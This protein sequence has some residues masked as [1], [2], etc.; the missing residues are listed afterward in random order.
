MS[1]DQDRAEEFCKRLAML[2]KAVP[3]NATRQQKIKDAVFQ[4][5]R[6]YHSNYSVETSLPDTRSPTRLDRLATLELNADQL[7]DAV[8]YQRPN[9]E[10][11]DDPHVT[12]GRTNYA[13]GVRQANY[14]P[15]MHPKA[16][17]EAERQGRSRGVE[18]MRQIRGIPAPK[19]KSKTSG[20]YT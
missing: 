16:R 20:D 19:K 9:Y 13:A 18:W 4:Q 15:E 5:K 2:T 11:Y 17:A 12:R 14:L 8:R 6:R 10:G 1:Q 3:R 7:R